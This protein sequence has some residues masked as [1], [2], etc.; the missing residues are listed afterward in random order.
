MRKTP[1]RCK[2]CIHYELDGKEGYCLSYHLHVKAWVKRCIR[3]MRRL[4]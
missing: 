4:T 3:F 1:S 2:L